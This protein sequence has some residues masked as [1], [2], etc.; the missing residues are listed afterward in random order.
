ME[1]YQHNGLSDRRRCL[2]EAQ[3]CFRRGKNEFST[4]ATEEQLKLMENQVKLE[5]KF[6]QPFLG[7]SLQETMSK[8]LR[9]KE[10]KLAEGLKKDFKVPD[11]RY[12]LLKINILAEQKDWLELERFS[13]SKKSPIGYEV[14]ANTKS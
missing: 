7:L 10:V 6:K 12:W 14:K 1:A 2:L 9:D 4:M 3:E 8:L 11:R 13:K 5:E